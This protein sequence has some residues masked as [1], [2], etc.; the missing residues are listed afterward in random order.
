MPGPTISVEQGTRVRLR[1][2]NDLPDRHQLG[3]VFDTSTHLHGSPSRP[4]FDG[5]ASDLRPSRSFKD[6]EYDND[7]GA[8]TIWYHDHAVH[9]TA[10]NAY[11]SLGAHYHVHDERER[12]LLPQG[13][14]DV[15]LMVADVMFAEDGSSLT[16]TTA[17]P[18]CRRR[19]ARQRRGV[20]RDAGTA[21]PLPVPASERLHLPVAAT[22]AEHA[23]PGHDGRH[24][25]WAD[26]VRP[27]GRLLAAGDGGALRVPRRL[28]PLRARHTG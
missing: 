11:S 12:A 21:P 9:H 5:Y 17:R 16:T 8:R 23:R 7:T 20:A 24:R 1:V 28:L 13:A 10:E 2:R 26:A 22:P 25:R 19:A 18:G 6:Y 4:P 15:S 14:F 3:H 27:A